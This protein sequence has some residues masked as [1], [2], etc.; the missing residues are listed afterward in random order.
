MNG[1]L[2]G[3]TGFVGSPFELLLEV[4]ALRIELRRKQI[5]IFLGN[6]V[7]LLA[8]DVVIVREAIIVVTRCR[9]KLDE[10][11]IYLV[12]HNAMD[13]SIYGVVPDTLVGEIHG[14]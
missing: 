11:A 13:V 1:R 4:P 7:K 10:L 9:W 14:K 3:F 2:R 5:G 12:L 8:R 6:R